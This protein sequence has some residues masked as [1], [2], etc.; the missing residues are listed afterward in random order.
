[1]TTAH[2][3]AALAIDASEWFTAP[4]LRRLLAPR[5]WR[6]LERR[7]E[8]CVRATL[9]TLA[10]K[11]A[12][13][14]WFV[15]GALARSAPGLLRE[16]AAGGHEVALAAEAPWPL[17]DVPPGERAALQDRWLRDVAAIE[18]ATGDRKSVV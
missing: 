13:A 2:G 10:A 5:H 14:T 15:P 11:G 9:G 17:A 4:E 6:R 3:T 18:A 12:R 16:L 7:A 1:M 8:P